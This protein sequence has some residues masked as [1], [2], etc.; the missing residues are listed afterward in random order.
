M[1]LNATLSA[2][3]ELFAKNNSKNEHLSLAGKGAW[4][5]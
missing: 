4:K 2:N 5:Q 3:N 1:V